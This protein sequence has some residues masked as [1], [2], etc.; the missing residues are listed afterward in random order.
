MNP[1]FFSALSSGVFATLMVWLTS[2]LGWLTWAAF[3]GCASY[4]STRGDIRGLTE[5]SLTN[6]TGTGWAMVMIKGSLLLGNPLGYLVIAVV[7]FLMCMQARQSWLAYIPG[8]FIGASTVF[9][10]NGDWQAVVPPL[11]LGGVIGFVMKHSGLWL[12]NKYAQTVVAEK[13][14]SN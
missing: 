14:A 8:T 3:L 9:A 5:N 13:K 6:L 2:T 12:Y 7:S 11:L 1:L 10:A 4:F